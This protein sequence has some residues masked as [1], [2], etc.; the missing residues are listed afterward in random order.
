MRYSQIKRLCDVLAVI[1]LIVIISP[2]LLIIAFLIKLYDGGPII[3]RQKRIGKN[4]QEFDF[5]KFRSMPV[6]TPNVVST[7]TSVLKVT[8]IGRFIRRTNLDEIPQFL[9]VLKVA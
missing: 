1:M 7:Q 8:P 5:M 4:G 9:N 2:I 3:F 6:N